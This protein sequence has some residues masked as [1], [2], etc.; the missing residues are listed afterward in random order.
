MDRNRLTVAEQKDG[1]R[2]LFDGRSLDGWRWSISQPAPV[3]SWTAENG[4]LSTTP[5]RGV[6]VYLITRDSFSD[7]ELTFEWNAGAAANS[8]IKYRF[9]GYWVDGHVRDEPGGPQRIE[10]VALEYQISD[11][12]GNSDALSDPKHSAAAIYEYWPAKKNAPARAHKWHVGRIVT[13]DLRIQHWFDGDKVIDISLDAP[14]VQQSF[15]KSRRRGSSPLL[16]RHERRN[17]PIALQIH[18]G[19]VCFRNLKIRNI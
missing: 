5:D 6:P 4:L 2:L 15:A 18:D 1:W 14:E 7:F 17:S 13:K 11:D 10:P 9:Q 8:G 16:A 3:P 19:V 12:E